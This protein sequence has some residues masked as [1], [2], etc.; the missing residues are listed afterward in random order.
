MDDKY[1]EGP[2]VVDNMQ[3]LQV[4]QSEQIIDSLMALSTVSVAQLGNQHGSYAF[5]VFCTQVKD[6]ALCTHVLTVS[7]NG[8]YPLTM[9]SDPD[10]KFWCFSRAAVFLRKKM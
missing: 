6:I 1:K 9:A 4:S 8:A 3:N 2:Y 10:F 7:Q 5:S